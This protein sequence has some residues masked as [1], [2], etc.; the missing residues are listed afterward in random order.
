M[1]KKCKSK[2]LCAVKDWL[3]QRRV[4]A[5]LLSGAA[6]FGFNLGYAWVPEVCTLVAG[7]LALHSYVKP[8]K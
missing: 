3:K 7:L 4:W 1:A 8:R 2:L 5:A 6:L